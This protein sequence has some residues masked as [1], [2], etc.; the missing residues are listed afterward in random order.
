[1][2]KPVFYAIGLALTLAGAGILGFESQ[3]AAQDQ[4]Q[5][6]AAPQAPAQPNPAPADQTQ[7]N[8]APAN[9]APANAAPDQN[10]AAPNPAPANPVP[11]DQLQNPPPANPA[12]ANPAPATPP[13]QNQAAPNPAPANPNA[14]AANPNASGAATTTPTY[15]SPLQQFASQ[16]EDEVGTLS[17]QIDLLRGQNRPQA[18]LAL[19]HMIRDHQLLVDAARNV[20]A[21]R[22]DN[23]TL[24]LNPMPLESTDPQALYQN[25][26]QA[27]Q[28]AVSNLQQ[29]ISNT[30]AADEKNIYQRG[31]NV[32]NKHMQWLQ[33]LNQGQNLQIGFFGPTVPLDRI[34]GYREELNNTAAN[35]YPQPKV[36]QAASRQNGSYTHRATRR[37]RGTRR[38]RAR[39]T[40]QTSY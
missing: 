40:Q 1:M 18:V 19:Y 9:P 34:A 20:L 35:G 11:P 31:L 24:T 37:Y 26:I 4:T 23:A 32:A 6:N 17:Q 25:D 38:Y 13:D 27:H 36:Q 29:L 33:A 5:P 2:R 22:G 39:R 15:S 7:P 3:S 12:P 8:P 21:R 14:P 28:Q 16:Q 30:S 10:Q